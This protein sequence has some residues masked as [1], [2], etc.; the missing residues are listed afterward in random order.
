MTE[1]ERKILGT[2]HTEV[3]AL[4]AEAWGL[5]ADV[6]N[7]IRH[8][9][10]MDD[11]TPDSIPGIIQISDYLVSGLQYPAVNGVNSLLAPDLSEFIKSNANE[12]KAI[13][14]DLP[15]AIAEAGEI[16]NT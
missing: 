13:M 15:E 10:D 7:A 3:G 2:D 4:L 16:F 5:T 1:Y 12:F 9:H 11:I 8:H 14:Q 6:Q